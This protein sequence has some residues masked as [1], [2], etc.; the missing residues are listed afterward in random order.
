M[1]YL[2]VII[3]CFSGQSGYEISELRLLEAEE[4]AITQVPLTFCNTEPCTLNYT[5]T[6]DEKAYG[7]YT[8]RVIDNAGD[9]VPG[10]D[11]PFYIHVQIGKYMY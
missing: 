5:F 2:T 9:P 8:A 6:V 4:E 3:S 11:Y 10:A 1:A 7:K